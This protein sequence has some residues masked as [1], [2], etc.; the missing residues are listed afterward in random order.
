M[1]QIGSYLASI[2][3]HAE[4][5]PAW[6]C[7]G[8]EYLQKRIQ[9]TQI[10][11]ADTATNRDSCLSNPF[12]LASMC[13]LP[14]L[15]ITSSWTH[16]WSE[17]QESES[18]AARSSRRSQLLPMEGKCVTGVLV[19]HSSGSSHGNILQVTWTRQSLIP[20]NTFKISSSG[21]FKGHLSNLEASHSIQRS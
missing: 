18:N 5:A 19:Q 2:S 1:F 9:N 12:F 21:T 6:P 4:W 17:K 10:F 8:S 13:L 3:P 15:C 7:P 16:R 20:S 11:H 14:H